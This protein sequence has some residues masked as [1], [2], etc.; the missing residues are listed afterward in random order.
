MSLKKWDLLHCMAV[1][2]GLF[3]FHFT[4]SKI[5]VL[6]ITSL[7]VL[8]L[9]VSQWHT[10]NQYK[11]AG[12]YANL[13]TLL[14]F[15]LVIAITSLSDILPLRILGILYII[16]VSMDALDGFLARKMNHQS[17]FG[18]FFDM[19]TDS[20]F[21][22][23]AGLILVE[24][25]IAGAWILPAVYMR[26]IYVLVILAMGLSGR[27]EKRMRYGP[28]VTVFLFISLLAG[29]QLPVT[30]ATKLLAAAC[31]LVILSFGYSFFLI[32]SDRKN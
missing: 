24:K 25:Q 13:V 15:S 27:Q 28:A 26:Y 31:F 7:S 8:W 21:V 29:Y 5:P 11:P 20:L 22:A 17:K 10:I 18:A 14:R 32:V 12:G 1:S 9:W 23:L 30:Y 2:A 6:I 16:P 3:A 4:G 19:E